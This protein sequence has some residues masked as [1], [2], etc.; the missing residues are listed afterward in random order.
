MSLHSVASLQ[1]LFLGSDAGSLA[2]LK[3]RANDHEGRHTPHSPNMSERRDRQ[4]E[5]FFQQVRKA[6]AEEYGTATTTTATM[7][8]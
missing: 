6:H 1:L 8:R 4:K 5:V 7:I 3:A 2:W